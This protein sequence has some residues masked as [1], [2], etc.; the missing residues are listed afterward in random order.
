MRHILHAAQSEAARK[1]AVGELQRHACQQVSKE[2]SK[3][4]ESLVSEVAERVL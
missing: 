1:V 3:V 2:A 4:R